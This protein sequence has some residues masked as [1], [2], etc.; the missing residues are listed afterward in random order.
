MAIHLEKLPQPHLPR[1]EGL[2]KIYP[3]NSKPKVQNPMITGL[4]SFFTQ[5]AI[6]QKN[7]PLV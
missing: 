7:R 5:C 4:F 6:H 1:N 3:S 2:I